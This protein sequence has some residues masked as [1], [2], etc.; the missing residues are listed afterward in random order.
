[1]VLW[2]DGSE[3]TLLCMLDRKTETYCINIFFVRVLEDDVL[4]I[5]LFDVFTGNYEN[6]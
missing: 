2:L 6:L 1:M 3:C 5:K 4:F